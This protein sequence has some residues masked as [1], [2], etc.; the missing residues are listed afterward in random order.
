MCRWID[1]VHQDGCDFYAES[2]EPCEDAVSRKALQTALIDEELD[3]VQGISGRELCQIV[4]ALPTVQPKEKVGHW[5]DCGEREPWCRCS[6]CGRRV[7]GGAN[8]YY[9]NCGAKMKGE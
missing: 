1:E 9:P 5:S 7:W 4:E 3:Q 2:A 6:E 8:H